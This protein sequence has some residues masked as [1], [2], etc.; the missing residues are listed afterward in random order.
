PEPGSGGD[1][2][3][4]AEHGLTKQQFNAAMPVEFWREVVDRIAQEAPDTLLLAEA[5][6][7]MESYFVR[8][9]GMHRVYN[10]A[11]M[12][13]LRNEDNIRYRTLM[14]NTLEFDPEILKRYVNFM[15]NPDERTAV[16]QFGSGDKYFGICVLMST[17]PGLPMFGHG[18]VEGFQEKYGMEFRKAYLDESVDTGLVERHQRQIFPLLHRRSIFAGVDNFLLFDLYTASGQVNEDVFAFSNGCGDHRSLVIYHNRYASTSGWLRYSAAYAVKE[19]SGDRRMVQRTI[20]EGLQVTTDA[21]TFLIYK[22]QVSGLEFIRSCQEII[23]EGWRIDLS[24]YETHVYLDFRQVQDDAWHNYKHLTDLLQGRGVPNIEAA[25]QELTLSPV[26]E[27]FRQICN[28]EYFDHLWQ[29]SRTALSEAKLEAI[30]DEAEKKYAPFLDGIVQLSGHDHERHA[31]L[32][33]TRERLRNLL[34]ISGQKKGKKQAVS[35]YAKVLTDIQNKLADDRTTWLMML[36]LIFTQE[37]GRLGGTTDFKI[38]TQSWMVEWTLERILEETY[39]QFVGDGSEAR[40]M[41]AKVELLTGV[42]DWYKSARIQPLH[43]ILKNWFQDINIQKWLGVN[44]YQDMLYYNEEAMQEFIGWMQ[45]MAVFY[46]ASNLN[47][48]DSITMETVIGASQVVDQIKR[49]EIRA[50]FQVQKMLD[51]SRSV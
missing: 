14:K 46:P 19:P 20:A 25:K 27:P 8:T 13:L 45:L 15:N 38:Q 42:H 1:I 41:A 24:A 6:W 28:L 31:V 12:N 18:Q 11:F 21:D 50:Q 29:Q 17:L 34:T 51:L 44:R 10:S 7:L 43:T 48:P 47:R 35:E 33:N 9:L 49:L 2:P 5:F 39:A 32:A 26:I 30:L 36:G 23:E 4:R 37:I 16:D 40:Q 22:D 3:S